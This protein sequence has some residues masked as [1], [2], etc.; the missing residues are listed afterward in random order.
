MTMAPERSRTEPRGRPPAGLDSA[1]LELLVRYLRREEA[2][3]GDDEERA[4]DLTI[5]VVSPKATVEVDLEAFN[6]AR[7][8]SV[9]MP[10]VLTAAVQR[11]VGR[12]EFSQYV[13]EAVVEQLRHDLLGDL[14]EMHEAE[15]G[16]IPEEYLAEARVAW[17]DAK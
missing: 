9:S 10:A 4:S 6:R 5:D 7:K 15:H 2:Q 12:G 16:P 3:S 14:I 1:T 13:T 11:R 8:V 17:P